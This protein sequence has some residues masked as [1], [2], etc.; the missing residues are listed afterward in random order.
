MGV[1]QNG[2][3]STPRPFYVAS[4]RAGEWHRPRLVQSKKGNLTTSDVIM[5]QGHTAARNKKEK[6]V[7]NAYLHVCLPMVVCGGN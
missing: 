6:K 4:I 3:T 5:M 2:I 7:A 1:M